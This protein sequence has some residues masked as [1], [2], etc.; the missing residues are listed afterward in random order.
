M[1]FD[2]HAEATIDSLTQVIPNA[3]IT[4]IP[5]HQ[6]CYTTALFFFLFFFFTYKYQLTRLSHLNQ[7]EIYWNEIK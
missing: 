6:R 4:A 3:A 7:W 2:L 1:T 5:E